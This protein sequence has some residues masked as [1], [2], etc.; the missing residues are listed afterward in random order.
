[1]LMTNNKNECSD[2]LETPEFASIVTLEILKVLARI[3][4]TVIFATQKEVYSWWL[5][6]CSDIDTMNYSVGS[7]LKSSN[8]SVSRENNESSND[9]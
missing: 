3:I 4:F 1:M 6:K 7:T 5:N 2:L 8:I 9:I